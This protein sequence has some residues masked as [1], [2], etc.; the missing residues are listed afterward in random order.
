MF[1]ETSLLQAIPPRPRFRVA[2]S[3]P[4][5]RVMDNS[6]R[7]ATSIITSKTR[8]STAEMRCMS[9]P[10]SRPSTGLGE[11]LLQLRAVLRALLDDAGPAGLVGFVAIGGA[12]GPFELDHRNAGGFLLGDVG[13]VLLCRLRRLPLDPCCRIGN[14]LLLRVAELVPAGLVDQD[15][16][17]G[18]VETGI[19]AVLGLLMPAEIEDA[20]DRPTVAV[21]HTAL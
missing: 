18:A 21:D 1:S 3:A 7:Q 11:E 14:H 2:T 10:P 16:H 13:L 6:S 9:V 20:G 19:D 12:L 8:P 4:I 17:F 5:S 15:A